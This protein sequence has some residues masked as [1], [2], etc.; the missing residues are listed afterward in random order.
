MSASITHLPVSP[1][2]RVPDEARDDIIRTL[3]DALKVAREGDVSDMMIILQHRDNYEWSERRA[4]I[5]SGS[6]GLLKWIGRL[7]FVK[8]DWIASMKADEEE[9]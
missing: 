2:S 3:E 1:L 5:D 9:A 8:A 4:G 6:L 7:E